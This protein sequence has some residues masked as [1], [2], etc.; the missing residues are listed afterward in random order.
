MCNA[1]RDPFQ[2]NWNTECVVQLYGIAIDASSIYWVQQGKD[3]YL[4]DVMRTPKPH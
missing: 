2:C 4:F 1:L 3:V